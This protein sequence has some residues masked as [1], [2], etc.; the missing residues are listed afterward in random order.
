MSL[1]SGATSWRSWAAER[2]GVAP[3]APPERLRTEFLSRLP[4]EDFQ[5]SAELRHS[6]I[7]LDDTIKEGT[8]Q[9]CAALHARQAEQERLEAEVE[10][11]AQAFWSTPR[12]TRLEHWDQLMTAANRSPRARA[13]L[14]HLRP[15]LA[16]DSPSGRL[17]DKNVAELLEQLQALAVCVPF[18][19][20]ALRRTF[21]ADRQ[22]KASW[23]TAVKQVRDQFPQ[24]AALQEDFLKTL[25]TGVPATVRRPSGK[26]VPSVASSDLSSGGSWSSGASWYPFRFIGPLLL[27]IFMA[28][29]LFEPGC[30]SHPNPGIDSRS[31]PTT[32]FQRMNEEKD[33]RAKPSKPGDWRRPP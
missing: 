8:K 32:L 25:A 3:D 12:S 18:E 6:F 22:E 4:G 33:P 29:R 2:L 31:V 9:R 28:T 16:V 11:F 26:L 15:A 19:Q 30:N 10:A 13:R 17:D 24:L 21:L 27:V 5:P 20:A 7:L 23:R 1:S 14:E